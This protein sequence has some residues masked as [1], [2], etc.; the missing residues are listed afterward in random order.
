MVGLP[1]SPGVFQTSMYPWRSLDIL[2]Q[3]VLAL[4]DLQPRVAST[5]VRG[6]TGT[7][8]PFVQAWP[9]VP[10]TAG[11]TSDASVLGRGWRHNR[12]QGGTCLVHRAVVCLVAGRQTCREAFGLLMPT[13]MPGHLKPW[14]Q[15]QD[16]GPILNMI[17]YFLGLTNVEMLSSSNFLLWT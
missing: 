12:F 14:T 11:R 13:E 1:S 10:S 9:N 2:S 5:L 16:S 3:M 6:V 17:V 8:P 4:W 15:G 7:L